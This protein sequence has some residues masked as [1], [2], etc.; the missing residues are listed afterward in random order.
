MSAALLLAACGGGNA[1]DSGAEKTFL[2]VQA[3]DAQ[4][5]TLS[6]QWRVTAGSI[7]NRNAAETVWTLPNTK[8]LHFAYVLIS[9]GKGGYAQQ[10][11]AVSSDALEGTDVA[12]ATSP[13][14][15]PPPDDVAGSSGR[16]RFFAGD[17]TMFA[18]P[19]GGPAVMRQV[20]LPDTRV[21]LVAG[22][23][24]V[25]SG[26]TDL[27]G[28]ISLP[29]LAAGQSY[30]VRCATDDASSVLADCGTFTVSTL[31]RRSNYVPALASSRNLRLYG[32]VGLSDGGVCAADDEYFGVRRSATVRLLAADGTPLSA[33]RRVN[34]FGD[35]LIDASV[36]VNAALRLDVQCEGLQQTVAVPA[37]AA[38]YDA[39]RPIEVSVALNNSRPVVA[40]MVANGPDGN[41]RGRMIVPLQDAE[42]NILPGGLQ[43]LS[44]KGLDTAASA[45]RYYRSIGAVRDCDAQGRMVEPIS[46]EAWKKAR[47]FAP[48]AS[49]GRQEVKSNYINKM[50]LNLVRRMVAIENA[51]DDIA[52]YVCNAP[53]PE[54]TTQKEIDEVM[55]SGLNGDRLVACVAMEWSTTAG[56]NGG[57]PFTKFLTFGPDGSLL[58]S[59]NLDGRGEKFLP[60]TCVACHGGALQNGRFPD[61]G[62]PSPNLGSRFLPFDTGNYFFGSAAGLTEGDQ[63]ASL[64]ALNQLVR[65][66]EESATSATSQLVDGWY[67][68]SNTTLDKSYVPPSWLAADSQPATAGAARLYR[69]VVGASCRTCHVAMGSAFNWDDAPRLLNNGQLQSHV[70]GGTEDLAVNASMPNALVS[71]DRV[72]ERVRS[73]PAVAALMTKFF[74]CDAPKPDPAYPKR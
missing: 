67:A 29:R 64:Y 50:D 73:D 9:D 70:C 2:K 25:F 22:G 47:G 1:N 3:N 18:P 33:S 32:H 44:Y 28:E 45:C 5:D 15:P 12:V 55:T 4:G 24:A 6:Y 65:K 52:F 66:T 74:G 19:G 41:V 51:P 46:F 38:G 56:V 31:G 35:Y 39:T 17:A 59:V 23:T 26:L 60:G 7:D 61:R 53:G 68:T 13:H 63:G 48:Y 71:R 40:K 49:A 8:G 27:Q 10:Q 34:R 36:P 72:A 16:L 21:E 43:F 30:T 58:P 69:E 42:S 62:N 14:T 20:Y 57:R 11:Y 37:D 54:G